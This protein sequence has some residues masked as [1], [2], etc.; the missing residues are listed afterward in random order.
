M[1]SKPKFT[2]E[3]NGIYLSTEC[4]QILTKKEIAEVMKELSYCEAEDNYDV[5]KDICFKAG[6]KYYK[7]N[8]LFET[9]F[10]IFVL[11]IKRISVD[12]LLDA[13]NNGNYIKHGVQ[14]QRH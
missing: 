5:Y 7:A 11:D 3:I 6:S 13:I 12:T 4:E 1:D 10:D 2:R 9:P 14:L 8:L